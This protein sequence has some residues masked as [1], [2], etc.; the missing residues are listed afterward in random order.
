MVVVVLYDKGNE[1][2][3]I[4]QG[5]KDKKS[6]VTQSHDFLHTPYH[7]VLFFNNNIYIYII[8]ILQ[9]WDTPPSKGHV[10]M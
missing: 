1:N 6:Q 9:E 3:W 7:S 5:K 4:V 8:I 2:I 10:T